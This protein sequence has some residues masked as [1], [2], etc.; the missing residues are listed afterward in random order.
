MEVGVYGVHFPPFELATSAAVGAEA[1]GMDFIICGHQL[2][3]TLVTEGLS[4]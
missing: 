1:A 2:C 3:F 4:T